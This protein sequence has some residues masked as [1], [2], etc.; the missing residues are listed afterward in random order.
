[1]RTPKL[2]GGGVTFVTKA[3]RDGSL[4]DVTDKRGMEQLLADTHKTK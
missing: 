2:R 3:E 1:M 4:T